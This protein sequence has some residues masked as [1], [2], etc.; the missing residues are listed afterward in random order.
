[1]LKL[2]VKTLMNVATGGMALLGLRD[3]LRRDG[4]KAGNRRYNEV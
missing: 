2:Q 3:A 1:M 4:A